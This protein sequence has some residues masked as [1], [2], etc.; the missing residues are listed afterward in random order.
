[1]DHGWRNKLVKIEDAKDGMELAD[2]ILADNGRII[3]SPGT[4]LTGLLIEKLK[5][6]GISEVKIKLLS[7]DTE[8]VHS[9]DQAFHRNYNSTVAEVRKAFQTIRY[10]KEISLE[11][12]FQL[13]KKNIDPLLNS[14][15]IISNLYKVRRI[16]DYTFHHSINVAVLS[17]ILG[18]WLGYKGDDLNKLVLAGLLHDVGKTQIPLK[19]LNKP[20]KLSAQE[21]N[22]M[23]LHTK[24]GYKLLSVVENLPQE[25]LF[26]SL[27]HHERLDG[28]G[29]PLE[30][31][32]SKIHPYAKIIAVCD[33]YDAM[34]SDRV[35]KQKVTPF[36]VL[37]T[38][39]EDMYGRLDPEICTTFL[40][41]VR[42]YFIGN[43][44]LLNDGR[45]GRVIQSGLFLSSRPVVQTEDGEFIDMETNSG[46]KIIDVIA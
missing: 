28:S 33:I 40:K 35:Y 5:W 37:E 15:G 9:F 13:Q 4:L 11:E 16:D 41:N 36:E 21:M 20:G 43:H 39:A 3:L 1:M 12:M 27:E 22:I 25:I 18:R 29:Y 6:W 10:F 42:E 8:Q 31:K 2:I 45:K 44:I 24:Q 30:I 32:S 19:I 38:I 34:T 23:Q 46:I 14:P 17:G 7:E 26:V